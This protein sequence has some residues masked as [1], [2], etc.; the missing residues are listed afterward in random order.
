[1]QAVMQEDGAHRHN[2][3]GRAGLAEAGNDEATATAATAVVTA[4]VRL[5]A[6]EAVKRCSSSNLH[7]GEGETGAAKALRTRSYV[8]NA[9][10]PHSAQGTAGDEEPKDPEEAA[11]LRLLRREDFMRPPAVSRAP[12]S[13]AATASAPA[14]PAAADGVPLAAGQATAG[15]GAAGGRSLPLPEG[16]GGGGYLRMTSPQGS[17]IAI[18]R[19]AYMTG[20][21]GHTAGGEFAAELR[22]LV[23]V[24]GGNIPLAAPAV[25]GS[26]VL[27]LPSLPGMSAGHQLGRHHYNHPSDQRASA[28]QPLVVQRTPP[29]AASWLRQGVDAA[30]SAVGAA[31]AAVHATPSHM[32][33]GLGAIVPPGTL[34]VAPSVHRGGQAGGAEAPPAAAPVAAAAIQGDAEGLG[35]RGNS[36]SAGVA[37]AAV[38][39]AA[40]EEEQEEVQEA[41]VPPPAFSPAQQGETAGPGAAAG[42]GHLASHG[43]QHS[44]G[45]YSGFL[46]QALAGLAGEV[47]AAGP[48]H[49]KSLLTMKTSYAVVVGEF[50]DRTGGAV[51]GGT[52]NPG[53]PHPGAEGGAGQ[54]NGPEAGLLAGAE[55]GDERRDEEGAQ[56][57]DLA[58]YGSGGGPVSRAAEALAGEEEPA[59]AGAPAAAAEHASPEAAE[60]IGPAA[61]RRDKAAAGAALR[62]DTRD[63]GQAF[64]EL[65]LEEFEEEGEGRKSAPQEA[66]ANNLQLEE[67]E[68]EYP[69]EVTGVAGRAAGEEPAHPE[70]AVVQEEEEEEEGEEEEDVS[71]L[72][73]RPLQSPL[74]RARPRQSLEGSGEN[75]G[76]AGQADEG[77]G[78]LSMGQ[79]AELGSPRGKRTLPLPVASEGGANEVRGASPGSRPQAAVL[80]LDDKTLRADSDVQRQ[81]AGQNAEVVAEGA[82]E[83]SVLVFA[84]RSVIRQEDARPAAVANDRISYQV[85]GRPKSCSCP[86]L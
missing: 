33:G 52:G 5:L 22:Q 24:E 62:R 73:G 11:L 34:A 80:A 49:D 25:S 10:A 59:A 26:N 65:I 46:G 50:S 61:S 76:V 37:P 42:S 55:E 23:S 48:Q 67:V 68:D 28:Q 31:A 15:D 83:K 77:Q 51:V 79:R 18:A 56:V 32:A 35:L 9:A 27:G 54:G 4:A 60:I 45:P 58:V 71:L 84:A 40:E 63:E 29:A 81:S 78:V 20:L 69:Q 75:R 72:E 14:A 82:G 21:E 74:T 43:H 70:A 57:A 47:D 12:R 66:T 8:S 39:A 86:A 17:T 36:A 1:M 85:R 53:G 13:T 64:G 16:G 38:A 7:Q 30:P 44:P 3:G 2:P 19:D 41:R 6:A